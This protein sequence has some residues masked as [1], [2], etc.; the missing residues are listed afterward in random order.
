M[1][2]TPSRSTVAIVT[3]GCQMNVH[4]SERIAGLM[5]R[6]GYALVNDPMA[7]DCVILNT[8]AVREKAEQK[9]YS[10]LGRFREIK[11]SRPGFLLGVA[12]CVAQQEGARIQ[13][14]APYVD[15][16]FGTTNL[17]DLPRLLREAQEDHPAVETAFGEAGLAGLVP[18][19]QSR[20]QAHVTIMHGCDRFC[21]FCVIPRLRGREHSRPPDEIE[22]EVRDL[23]AAG[24]KEV[25]LLGQTVSSYGKGLH[26]AID[27]AGLIERL[28]DIEGIARIRFVSPHPSDLTPRLV[29]CFRDL[30]KA[31]RHIHL[32]L[33]SGSDRILR[34]M[35]RDY[36]Y[37][38]YREWIVSLRVQ[39]PDITISTD[40]IAGF[41]GETPRDHEASVRA[42]K[43]IR[44]DHLFAFKYSSRARTPALRL[45]GHVPEGLKEERL[46]ELL[47]MQNPISL[48]M[49]SAWI[50]RIVSVLVEGEGK[51]GDGKLMGRTAGNHA[52]HLDG[53]RNLAGEMVQVR[54]CKAGHHSLIGE[55]AARRSG[56]EM[57]AD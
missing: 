41:P 12:G 19:R 38:E 32:P 37:N 13:S 27:L 2:E 49:N 53:S 29:S 8:C 9:F 7:A 3:F 16:V 15:F 42:L 21:A 30:P 48:E 43:E 1:P 52:V 56:R 10:D 45:S 51:K 5:A 46:A 40:L 47:S 24:Y 22:R 36:A 14:R 33:Q 39:V 34:L 17:R 54:I 18:I 57:V 50:G 35:R 23:A 20:F 4:D 31:A 44:F 55:L 28:H 6:E 26:P 25:T 11:E